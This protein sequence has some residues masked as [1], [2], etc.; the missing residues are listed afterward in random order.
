MWQCKCVIPALVKLRQE[1]SRPT[2]DTQCFQ[3][4]CLWTTE[5]MIR[6][7]TNKQTNIL[8]VSQSCIWTYWIKGSQVLQSGDL[9]ILQ[10][11]SHT[12]VSLIHNVLQ[13]QAAH[14]ITLSILTAKGSLGSSKLVNKTQWDTKQIAL[15]VAIHTTG[16]S[17]LSPQLPGSVLWRFNREVFQ[18][19]PY[20]W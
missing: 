14:L 6:I 12:A 4:P 2:W 9:V 8:S 3:G 16:S 18:F 13:W 17:I 11:T 10:Q 5:R 15:R 1:D 20:A 19:W 7:K